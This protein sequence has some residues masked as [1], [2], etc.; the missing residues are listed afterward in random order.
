MGEVSGLKCDQFIQQFPQYANHRMR[1]EPYE[2]CKL[3]LE[4]TLAEGCK[5]YGIEV[6]DGFLAFLNSE[7][8]CASQWRCLLGRSLTMAY[9]VAMPSRYMASKSEQIA[10]ATIQSFKD[11]R[12]RFQKMSCLDPETQAQFQCYLGVKYGGMVLGAAGAARAAGSQLVARMASLEKNMIAAETRASLPSVK[13]ATANAEQAGVRP[14][15]PRAMGALP[16]PTPEVLELEAYLKKQKANQKFISDDRFEIVNGKGV[17]TIDFL[18]LEDARLL[19]LMSKAVKSGG[20]GRID[21]GAVAG[22][23]VLHLLTR[24][25]T[26]APAN[27]PLTIVGKMNPSAISKTQF[28]ELVETRAGK[29]NSNMIGDRWSDQDVVNYENAVRDLHIQDACFGLYGKPM[30]QCGSLNFSFDARNPG[31]I[32][33]SK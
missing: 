2:I 15:A 18:N 27:S 22:P 23:K 26:V 12:D 6:K 24:L 13:R 4:S 8:E 21:A 17:L 20:I 25:K 10:K 5:R 33:W 32:R 28:R 29:N 31:G 30:H 14:N 19:S 1:C 9:A 7:A 11:D 3:A 16:K